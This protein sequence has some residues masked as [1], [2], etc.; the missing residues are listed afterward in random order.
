[1]VLKHVHIY[2]RYKR[3]LYKC[4]DPHCTHFADREFLVGKATLCSKCG[5]EFVLTREDLKRKAPLCLNC[6]D[7]KEA[8]RYRL[9]KQLIAAVLHEQGID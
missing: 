5:S 6:S 9:S 4:N 1:M 7:T 2:V 8:K 3:G